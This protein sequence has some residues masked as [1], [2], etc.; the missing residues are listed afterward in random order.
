MR[1]EDIDH[2]MSF[3]F[4]CMFFGLFKNIAVIRQSMWAWDNLWHFLYCLP[5][6]MLFVLQ[7]GPAFISELLTVIPNSHYYKRGTYDLKKV[8]CFIPS[9]SNTKLQL[10]VLFHDGC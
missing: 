3:Q 9:I 7:R 10:L 5:V 6:Y 4:Q 2:Y 1:P 8:K